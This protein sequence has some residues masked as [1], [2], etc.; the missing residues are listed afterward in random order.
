MLIGGLAFLATVAM[1]LPEAR[2]QGASEGVGRPGQGQ[3]LRARGRAPG[4]AA[5]RL[6]ARLQLAPAQRQQI[7]ALRQ[8]MRRDIADEQAQLRQV[9]EQLRAA[10]QAPDPQGGRILELRRQAS[11]LRDAIQARRVQ[12]RLAV[13]RV[14]TPEQRIELQRMLAEQARRGGARRIEPQTL[15]P[16]E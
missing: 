3:A 11:A 13:F 14:L 4:L 7:Q 2:A 16:I 8:E 1:G 9:S 10:W 5:K 15:L 12:F 6:A